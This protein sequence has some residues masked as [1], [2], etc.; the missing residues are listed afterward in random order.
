MKTATANPIPDPAT[1]PPA[2]ARAARVPNVCVPS[3]PSRR[4]SI[5]ASAVA[6]A[7]AAAAFPRWA[8]RLAYDRAAISAG[9]V[10]RIATGHWLHAGA[11]H[12]FWDALMFG[13]AG[14]ILESRRPRVF[15]WAVAAWALGIGAALF[16]FAPGLQSYC[17]LS[18]LCTA[19]FVW[20]CDCFMRDGRRHGN[21]A[22]AGGAVLAMV[23]LGA[24]IL[25][26][27][28]TG[29]AVF[30]TEMAEG[31]APLPL[32]HLLGLAA[33][34]IA[35]VA[36]RWTGGIEGLESEGLPCDGESD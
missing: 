23:G 17:G 25:Y 24:K 15:A 28:A 2:G 34:A 30:V 33:G 1:I 9:E 16:A 29:R 31:F 3:R 32:A 19:A 10:W 27:A 22:L 8:E 18:G 20:V 14:A 26:E 6:A 12:L 5:S 7:L 4:A 21:R 36:D 13:A 11:S 35:A